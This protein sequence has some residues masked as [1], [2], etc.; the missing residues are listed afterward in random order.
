MERL[1]KKILLSLI[2]SLILCSYISATTFAE[3]TAEIRKSKK[4]ENK[5][6]E[7]IT[8]DE[9]TQAERSV[10]TV[11]YRIEKEDVLG[12]Y[13]WRHPEISGEVVVRSDGMISFSLLGDI[14]ASGLALLELKKN[15]TQGLS[16]FARERRGSSVS[17]EIQEKEEYLIK[18][19]DTLNILVRRV[20]DLSREVIVRPDGMISFPLIGDMQA[21]SI[22]LAQLNEELTRKLSNY[23]K[24]PQ[25]SV[26]I[27]SFGR[28]EGVSIEI[29]LE[30]EP[31]VS[32]MIKEFGGKKVIVLGEVAMPGVY[33]F[34]SDIRLTEAI[35]LAG[36]YT[37][38]AVK[39]NVLVIRGDIRKN[40]QVNV[41]NTTALLKKGRLSEN[42]LIQSQDIVYVP[43]T[44]IGNI[45]TFLKTITPVV[46]S[47]Y[48]GIIIE[49]A[50]SR[51]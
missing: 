31:E 48:K 39:K 33:A 47:V 21:A 20:I 41:S 14:Q 27:K 28:K 4:A 10:A 42:V 24:E 6:A 1:K 37:N 35:A 29:F 5:E 23:I 12:I 50:V 30:D 44:L 36:D 18:S 17:E 45:N 38:Y 16:E 9:V 11:A 2:T 8:A 49:T 32:V 15:I 40:P 13:V 34:T 22:T 25:V 26:M 19:G 46:D 7:K 43:N 51:D 3:T